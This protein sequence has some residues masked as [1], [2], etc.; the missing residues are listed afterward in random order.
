MLREKEEELSG[1]TVGRVPPGA[2][3]CSSLG[4]QLTLVPGRG[5]EWFHKESDFSAGSEHKKEIEKRGR[6]IAVRENSMYKGSEL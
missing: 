5:W 3:K 4:R 1:N 6:H 2:V